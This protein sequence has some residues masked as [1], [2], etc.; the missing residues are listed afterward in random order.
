MVIEN[1]MATNVARVLH[2]MQ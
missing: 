2:L 1:N